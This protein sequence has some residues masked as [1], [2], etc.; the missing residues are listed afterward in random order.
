MRKIGPINIKR[1]E[2]LFGAV[3]FERIEM[4][5]EDC[6]TFARRE[7]GDRLWRVLSI[8][9]FNRTRVCLWNQ[10]SPTCCGWRPDIGES[11]ALVELGGFEGRAEIELMSDAAA[12]EWEKRV[13]EIAPEKNRQLYLE[14]GP[15]VLAQYKDACVAADRYVECFWSFLSTGIDYEEFFSLAHRDKTDDLAKSIGLCMVP[16]RGRGHSSELW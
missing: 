2:K 4:V 10:V 8:Q 3:E 16:I 6:L 14:K 12:M 1:M 13:V 5:Q 15:A 11:S 9:A 7:E